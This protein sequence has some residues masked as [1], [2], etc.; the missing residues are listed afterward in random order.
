MGHG[1]AVNFA[2]ILN[3]T[4]FFFFNFYKSLFE[5]NLW[6]MLWSKISDG[7]GTNF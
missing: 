1:K 7:L 5:P 4:N 2:V 3:G 6:H